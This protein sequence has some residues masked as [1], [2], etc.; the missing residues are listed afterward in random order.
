MPSGSNYQGHFPALLRPSCPPRLLFLF[1][2]SGFACT[3]GSNYY[4][5]VCICIFFSV[6]LNRP[7]IHLLKK[8]KQMPSG[9]NYQGPFPA[10][11]RPSC[12]PRLLFLFLTSSFAYTMGSNYHEVAFTFFFGSSTWFS[13]DL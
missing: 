12:P 1:L 6:S 4:K 5:V 3:M 13:Q 9:S 11:L 10:L 7:L 8:S 2:T